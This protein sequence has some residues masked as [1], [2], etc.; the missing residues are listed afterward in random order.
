MMQPSKLAII[1]CQ[2]HRK[3]DDRVTKGNNTA[4]D[5][6]KIASKKSNSH[7]SSILSTSL[8]VAS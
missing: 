1:K 6:A 7:L 4:D 2:V 8:A 3:G 5:A